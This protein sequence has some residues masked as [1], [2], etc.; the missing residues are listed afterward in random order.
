MGVEKRI[1]ALLIFLGIGAMT[2][3]G[4]MIAN[5]RLVILGTEAHLGIS[6][7]L[8]LGKLLRFG[9]SALKNLT[10]YSLHPCHRGRRC[11][12]GLP[13]RSGQGAMGA[14]E[15][16]PTRHENRWVTPNDSAVQYRRS[17][18]LR[19]V[20]SVL[21]GDGTEGVFFPSNR[22]RILPEL[23]DDQRQGAR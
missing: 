9:L 15:T 17:N 7:A 13:C 5:P 18:L 1:I 21:M 23:A 11:N 3:F 14:V 10:H 8:I 16:I 12:E 22:T 19:P 20:E 2:D 6:M 4:P